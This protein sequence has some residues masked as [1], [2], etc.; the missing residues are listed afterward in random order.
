MAWLDN[1]RTSISEDRENAIATE[2]ANKRYDDAI[3][4]YVKKYSSWAKQNGGKYAD[5]SVED[6][7]ARVKDMAYKSGL[8]D[9][10]LKEDS[11]DRDIAE[12]GANFMQNLM[13]KKDDW[14]DMTFNEYLK[15]WGTKEEKEAYDRRKRAVEGD[16]GAYDT[17]NSPFTKSYNRDLF[18]DDTKKL[19]KAET[20][21]DKFNKQWDTDS[22]TIFENYEE[23]FAKKKASEKTSKKGSDNKTTTPAEASDEDTVTI[24]ANQD[25]KGFAQ[26]LLD[27]GLATDHGLWGNDGD[28]A[29]YTKQLYDQGALDARGN[30]RIGVPIKLKRRKNINQ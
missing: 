14:S 3:S 18:N 29:F 28:V 11:S 21:F 15:I 22:Y 9:G 2:K 4:E 30:L 12:Y 26:R 5:S 16:R 10:V 1:Y 6:L 25:G 13:G 27:N 19:S 24:V 8:Y 20:A 23:D 17:W 7:T